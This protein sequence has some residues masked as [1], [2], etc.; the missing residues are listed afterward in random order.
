MKA[1]V[2]GLALV[3][4]GCAAIW[5][6]PYV[7]MAVALAFKLLAAVG[8]IAVFALIG[9]ICYRMTRAKGRRDSVVIFWLATVCK[10]S[11]DLC[12]AS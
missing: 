7:F 6:L 3:G 2:L 5:I 1:I 8:M 11:N 4:L 9:Y 12:M 10:S